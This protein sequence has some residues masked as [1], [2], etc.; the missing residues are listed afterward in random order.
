VFV[1][2]DYVETMTT[3]F[4]LIG[5]LFMNN[6]CQHLWGVSQGIVF[7]TINEKK[8]LEYFEKLRKEKNE[9]QD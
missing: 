4:L 8:F 7:T 9:I 5:L 1:I 3:K 6:F 2:G